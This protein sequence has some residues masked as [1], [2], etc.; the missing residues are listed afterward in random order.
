MK[1]PRSICTLSRD[2]VISI[3]IC[4]VSGIIWFA[5]NIPFYMRF[6]LKPFTVTPAMV[7]SLVINFIFAI[8]LLV[9]KQ[10][11]N[12]FFP[13][14]FAL[15]PLAYIF[16]AFTATYFFGSD[17]TGMNITKKFM[18]DIY[19]FVCEIACMLILALCTK[20][21][22]RFFTGNHANIEKQY[23]ITDT[24]FFTKKVRYAINGWSVFFAS[25]VSL[26]TVWI[27]YKN[28]ISVHLFLRLLVFQIPFAVLLAF[29]E[30]LIFR[31]LLVHNL[32]DTTKSQLISL[33]IVALFW[34]VYHAL[35]G[36]AVGTGLL[37]GIACFVISL[38]WGFVTIRSGNIRNA[39]IGHFFIEMYGFYLMYGPYLKALQ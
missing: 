11:K 30:E 25:A 26:L 23:L 4:L 6:E 17:Y 33:F 34:G 20:Q 39:F 28:N 19:F 8:V 15:F 35:F 7:Y 10:K 22:F 29:K 9:C 27:I 38:W 5:M 36:E 16:V 3:S 2:S 13:F 32:I 31:W 18:Y 37:S 14:F 24:R 12:A 1:T 21:S